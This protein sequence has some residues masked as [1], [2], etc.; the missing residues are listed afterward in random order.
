[1]TTDAIHFKDRYNISLKRIAIAA[2][3]M[4]MGFLLGRVRIMA[5]LSPF[6]TAFIAACFLSKRPE[7]L[8][9]AAGVI[10]GALLLPDTTLYISTV[11]LVL[12]AVLLIGHKRR[13]RWVALVATT[14]AYATGIAIFKTQEMATAMT[15]VLECLMALVMVYVF[16]NVLRIATTHSK[17]TVFSAEETVCLALGAMSVICM[18]GPLLIGGVYVAHIVAMAVVLSVAYIGGGALGA[19]VGL[20]LGAACCLGISSEVQ[21]IGMFGISGMA[22]GTLR[23]LKKPGAAIGFVLTNLMFILAL[24][25]T[26]VWYLAMI[27]VGIAA[28]IF[29]L[30]PKKLLRFAGRYFDS[31]TRRAYEHRLHAQR[32]RELTVGRL[33]EVSEVFLQTGRMFTDDTAQAM[34]QSDGISGVLSVVADNACRDCVFKKSCWDKDFIST[35]HVFTPVSYTHL[36]AHET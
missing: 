22:A 7:I 4:A 31:Q 2:A 18:L 9:S 8:F 26:A 3:F 16:H 36:R 34:R 27:E 15:A 33:K 23:K 14:L 35:Y 19:G 25:T 5:A 20:A 17:R 24:Y 12:C 11:V 13:R 32:F 6:G 29:M 21:C 1:M 30:L 10:L 28:M